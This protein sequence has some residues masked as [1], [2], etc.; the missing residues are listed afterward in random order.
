MEAITPRKPVESFPHTHMVSALQQVLQSLTDVRNNSHAQ[1]PAEKCWKCLLNVNHRVHDTVCLV[2]KTDLSSLMNTICVDFLVATIHSNRWWIP[3]W[4]LLP[5]GTSGADWDRGV[6]WLWIMIWLAL[7]PT[8]W[9][10]SCIAIVCRESTLKFCALDWKPSRRKVTSATCFA[11]SKNKMQCF[12]R[13]A[14]ANRT[15]ALSA[16]FGWLLCKKD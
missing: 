5:E 15:F 9:I 6:C 16:P 1:I 13:D 8:M 10:C 2:F 4:L 7:Q 12:W 14:E 11:Y 3:T